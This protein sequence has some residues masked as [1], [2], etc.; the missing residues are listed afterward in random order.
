MS[1]DA[2]LT[3][4]KK[5]FCEEKFQDFFSSTTTFPTKGYPT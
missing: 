2:N 5:F 4:K 3:A 1:A